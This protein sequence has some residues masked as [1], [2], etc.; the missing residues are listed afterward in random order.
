MRCRLTY[1]TIICYK[2]DTLGSKL[3]YDMNGYCNL[4]LE[5]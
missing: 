3:L 1:I 2:L 4:T 5:Y